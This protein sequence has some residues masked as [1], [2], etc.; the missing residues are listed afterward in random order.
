MKHLILALITLSL[1]LS[2]FGDTIRG[3]KN[4]RFAD[5]SDFLSVSPSSGDF[6]EYLYINLIGERPTDTIFNGQRVTMVLVP[7]ASFNKATEVNL[8]V[9]IQKMDSAYIDGNTLVILGTHDRLKLGTADYEEEKIAILVT[10]V[11][12]N[13]FTVV[14]KVL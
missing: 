9:N 8:R 3:E 13:L 14:Q 4:N 2:A 1:T 10:I 12:S 6:A 7:K 5:I 11:G